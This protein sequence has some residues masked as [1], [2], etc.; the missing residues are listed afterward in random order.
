MNI[1]SHIENVKADL[2]AAVLRLYH[3]EDFK[4]FIAYLEV[5]LLETRAKGD[6]MTGHEKEW[7]QGWCQALSYVKGM[8]ESIRAQRMAQMG[9]VSFPGQGGGPAGQIN[10]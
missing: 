6:T 4:T 1:E 5:Y 9:N 7:N 3:N 10:F 2:P 8:P